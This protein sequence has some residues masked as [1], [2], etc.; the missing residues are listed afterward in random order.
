M[1]NDAIDLAIFGNERCVTTRAALGEA[2]RH[3]TA[4]A[5]RKAEEPKPPQLLTYPARP[6]QGGRLE[7]AP[8]K[9]GVWFAEPKMNGWRAV[10][11]TSSATMWNRHGS[12]LTIAHCFR[13][14]L[15]ELRDLADEGLVWADCEAL[16]RRHD[17]ARG[18]L[19][20]LDA[21][22][23]SPTFSP[24]YTERRAFLESLG[25]PQERFSSGIHT[26]DERPLLLTTS[27]PACP[28]NELLAFYQT[29]H[30]ANHRLGCEFFEGVVMKRGNSSYP[31]QLRSSTEKCREWVKHRFLN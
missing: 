21:I 7:L 10:V 13:D 4:K 8:P 14:A 22:P 20:V 25:I 18:T 26:G 3:I 30:S 28:H 5:K 31:V 2:A 23:A 27:V 6:I 12:R 11:H 17:V 9:R 16:D 24:A 29:L 15:D 1:M 19:I